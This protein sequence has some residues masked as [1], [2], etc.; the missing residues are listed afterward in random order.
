MKDAQLA[1][2]GHNYNLW[3][4]PSIFPTQMEFVYQVLQIDFQPLAS[5]YPDFN[6]DML[7]KTKKAVSD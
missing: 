3:L 1:F 4:I 7:I 2:I 6:N 5:L